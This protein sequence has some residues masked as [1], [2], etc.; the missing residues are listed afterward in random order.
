[1]T[2]CSPVSTITITTTVTATA[3]AGGKETTTQPP[4][5]QPS[6]GNNTAQ[7]IGI[8]M[9]SSTIIGVVAAF[10]FFAGHRSNRRRPST[11]SISPNLE[12]FRIWKEKFI[13]YTCS[14]PGRIA[15][16]ELEATE[17]VREVSTPPARPANN[18]PVFDHLVT[19]ASSVARG[20][21]IIPR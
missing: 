19:P 1:M 11:H 6:F 18:E 21:E 16:A 12:S 3:P 15:P 13:R 4:T 7:I 8:A 10:F 9:G 2:P 17:E 20:L 5:P 14:E